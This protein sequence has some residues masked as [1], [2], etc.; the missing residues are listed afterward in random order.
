MQLK[1][2]RRKI[3]ITALEREGVLA[4]MNGEYERVCELCGVTYNEQTRSHLGAL[5]TD[6]LA[7]DHTDE[8]GTLW[9]TLWIG[10]SEQNG[11]FIGAV[12]MMGKPTENRELTMVLHPL[13][14]YD[15][16]T[17]AYVFSHVCEW[18]CNHRVVY[19]IRIARTEDP[20]QETFL[21]SFGFVLNE[22][23][24]FFEREKNQSAWFL[25]CLSVG[26]ATGVALG[27]TFGGTAAGLAVGG[28]FGTTVGWYLDHCDVSR[29][30]SK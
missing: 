8:G 25:I 29:R 10:V 24:G 20:D 4:L 22:P 15:S 9:N 5:V 23:D 12:R 14:G 26:L 2:K 19:Y 7:D 3:T 6:C 13:G 27:D 1:S 21:R 11:D 30:K 18:A 28:L 17:F 16:P